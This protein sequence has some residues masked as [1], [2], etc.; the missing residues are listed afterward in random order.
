MGGVRSRREVARFEPGYV[1]SNKL[2]LAGYRQV[3]RSRRLRAI[4]FWL[5]RSRLKMSLVARMFHRLFHDWNEGDFEPTLQAVDP[6]IE[7]V[8]FGLGTY[9]GPDGMRRAWPD[10][11]GPFGGARFEVIE[12]FDNGAGEILT[13]AR[14]RSGEEM[15]GVTLKQQLGMV[16]TVERGTGVRARLF[17]TRADALEAVGLE[18]PSPS[19]S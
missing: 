17:T 13:I 18:Q 6:E 5:P 7:L 4:A 19:A 10:V 2:T 3:V 12:V 1:V 9:R 11:T 16:W 8:V 15:S 14:A